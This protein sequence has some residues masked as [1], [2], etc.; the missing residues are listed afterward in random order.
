MLPSIQERPLEGGAEAPPEVLHEF[1][2]RQAAIRPD[3]V[4]VVCGGKSW[5]YGELDGH[6]NQ[7][8]RFLRNCGIGRGECVGLLLPRS[9]DVYM[10]LLCILKAGAAYVPLD[11][12]YPADRVQFILADCKA[13]ALVTTTALEGK[14]TGFRGHVICLDEKRAAI[15]SISAEGLERGE[16]GARA[17]DLAYIIYTSGTTGRPKGV[18]IEH[19]SVCHLVRA[20]SEIFQ[21]RPNDRVYQGF[22]LAFDASVEEI[23][24]A[25]FAGATLVGGTSEMIHAG[26]ALPRLLAEAGVT[27]LSCVPTLLSMMEEDVP[28]I[29]LLILGGEACPPDLVK[30]W[31]KPGRRVVNTY[32]PTE[33]TVIA[34]YAECHPAKPVTIG[35]PL[36]NY[37]VCILDEQLQPVH[38]GASGELC[39]GGIGLA[40]GYVGRP[41]LD[42]E[43]FVSLSLNGEPSQR[44]YRTGDLARRTGDGEIEFL[45]RLDA[46]VK[47]RGFRVE[48]S[49]IEAVLL[50]CRDVQAAAVALREDT[51]GV[52]QLVGYVVPRDNKPLAQDPLRAVLRARLPVY[53]IPTVL[54]TL[55]KLPIL[56]S[57]KVDRKALPAPSAEAGFERRHIKPPRTPLEQQL[58]AVWGRLF[59]PMQA[60]VTDDFF[61]ELGGHSLLAARMVSELR[62][63]P[64]FQRLSMLD[65]YQHPTIESLAAHFET[66]AKASPEPAEAEKDR[67]VER[68]KERS[69]PGHHPIS[70]TSATVPFWRH[71]WCG[72]AQMV[73]LFFV[74]SFFALQWLAPYLT[75]TVLVEEDYDFIEAVLGAFASLI[76][77]YPVMLAIPI[78]VKWLVIGRYKPGAYP[79][80]GSYYFRWWL[81]TTIEAAVPVGYLAGTPLLNIYLRLMGARIGRNVHLDSDSFAIYDLLSIGDDASINVDSNLLGYTVEDGCLKLGGI[82]I[83][84]RCFVG[85]RAAV[86]EDA[87]MED[88]SALEDLSLVGRGQ[89]IPRG[90]TWT[91]SP[92]RKSADDGVRPSPGAATSAG[93]TLSENSDRSQQ[94]RP[95][96]P[97]DGRTPASLTRRFF[98]GVLHGLG[99][100]IF[101]VLV[102]AALFPGIVVMN[103]LNYIDPYYWYLFLS[104]LVGF[105]FILLLA[106]EIAAVKWLLLGKVKPGRHPL[107]SFY[108]LRKWF[109]DQTMDLSLDVLGPLYASVYLAPWYQLLGA[110]LGKGAEVSTASFI[111]PDLLS[112]GEESFIADSVSLGAPRVRDGFM[113][114]GANRVGK[115]S[116]IGNSAMLPPGTV[117]GDSVLIGC[118]SAPP[119][120]PAD[121]LREDSTWLGSPPLFLPQREKSVAFGDE[122]TFNPPPRLRALRAAI[123]FV[124][125]ISP[126]TFFIVLLSLLF[127]ALL[128]IHDEYSLLHTL[129]LFPFLYIGCGLAAALFTIAAK[130][131]LVWRYRPGERPLWSSFVWRNELLNALHEHLAEPFLVGALT[132]T[133]FVCWYFRL[134]GAHIGRRVYME[135][136]DLSEFDLAAVGDEATLNADCTIQTHLFEDR[137]MKMDTVTIG[138]RCHVGAGSLVLYDTRMEDGAALGD[139]SLLMKGEV[140]PPGTRWVGIPARAEG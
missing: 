3:Q 34:T 105:S 45:G 71:F 50:E 60:G 86:R 81:T 115:R 72:T 17:R 98:F 48:L 136:T 112:I 74:L 31:W 63:T 90:E 5:T 67:G 121:A 44:F 77:L 107:H 113:N 82:A 61:L 132:G 7:L 37:A 87:R 43:K 128:L 111:S 33:A 109:V 134:L 2:A 27:V 66:S 1:F 80:W 25:F 55:P 92:G 130:W 38:D 52:Q 88:D 32:G 4:A 95:A 19:R 62:K 100:L 49:E 54:E 131:I 122:R 53:M 118:L 13:G 11:P 123:E 30:R 28:S 110:K 16:V 12:D 51:P 125:V 84:R 83:G 126:S 99:L 102:V 139:L 73:S 35:R 68:G 29:R 58:G 108:Y 79:L 78:I 135:T 47:I 93:A 91:G 129:L 65:V 26:P 94:P 140:L 76:V 39:I 127:S 103:Q 41:E 6:A 124:R 96:A 18:Q 10:A 97:G 137:V 75:Y 46:Q 9:L 40:R 15:L 138:P 8:A 14:A 116:F 20:E 24:L 117:I 23:W 101:P 104:P 106:L 36:S 133:P 56:P 57:G 114:I 64:P 59:A 85:A 120:N 42:R 22:S 69:T 89:V 119:P 21:V 70:T